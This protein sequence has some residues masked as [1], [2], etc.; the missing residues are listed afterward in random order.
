[1][2][3]PRHLSALEPRA[4][5]RAR[6]EAESLPSMWL[7]I[8]PGDPSDLR[9]CTGTRGGCF[10]EVGPA[11]LRALH[12]SVFESLSSSH[13][14]CGRFPSPCLWHL[15]SESGSAHS[16]KWRP[17]GRRRGSR[18][19]VDAPAAAAGLGNPGPL[20]GAECKVC[21]AVTV[22]IHMSGAELEISQ[23]RTSQKLGGSSLSEAPACL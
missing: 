18:S 4:L 21:P 16:E 11:S 15:Q 12:M 17:E 22:P 19:S 9:E 8:G 1:M 10:A 13:G 6:A 2:S 20:G 14:S 23:F 7:E 3:R 5:R